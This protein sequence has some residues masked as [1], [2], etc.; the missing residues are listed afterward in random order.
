MACSSI[1]FKNADTDCV[2]RFNRIVDRIRSVY[3]RLAEKKYTT[4]S[5]TLTFFLIMSLLP[6]LFWLFLIFGKFH[7]NAEE[8]LELDIFGGVKEL[9]L[10]FKESA[11][12]ATTGVSFTL[13]VTTLYSST[14]LFY[15]MR[16]SGEIIYA[17][18]HKGG[19][20]I[21]LSALVLIFV[22][23]LLVSI[24]SAVLLFGNRLFRL[25]LPS[26][27]AEL[28]VYALLFAIAFG[29]ALILNLYMCPYYLRFR[30]G[31]WGSLLSVSLWLVGSFGFT[32][33][34]QF[35]NP[36]KLYGAIAAVIVFLLWLYM[37]TVC[38]VIGVIFNQSR[39]KRKRFRY[40]KF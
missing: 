31:L 8:I 7:L 18:E 24:A 15:H 35:A 2:N 19:W 37:M 26:L 28:L 11:E 30:E 10:Y 12:S 5:G 38:F 34:L 17:T 36:G 27:V 9:L 3:Q 22:F 14:N 29:M 6:F 13:L 4:I 21:R 1:L 20:R 16:R 23:I 32:L 40:K 39:I 25:W 33:Y